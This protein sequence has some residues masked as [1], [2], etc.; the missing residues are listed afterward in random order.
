MKALDVF[1]FGLNMQL[2]V[3][4]GQEFEFKIEWLPLMSIS[5]KS[6]NLESLFC[7]LQLPQDFSHF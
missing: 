6:F 5:N 4:S 1:N 7:G 2:Q 3:L